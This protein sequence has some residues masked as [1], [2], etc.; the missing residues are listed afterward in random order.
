MAVI[1]DPT[2][3]VISL[4][5]AGAHFGA[6]ICNEPNSFSWNEL[7]TRDIDTAQAFYTQVFEW[8]IAGQDMGEAGVY[9]LVQGGENGGWAGMMSMPAEMPD[10]VPNHWVV[11]FAV[12]DLDD[13]VA[14]VIANGGSIVADPME[15]PG[16]GRM[17][18]AHDPAGGS[19]CV[20]QPAEAA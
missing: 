5:K 16:V 11:H 3:A 6:E 1:A 4:W 7:L 9:Q 20:M 15:I 18:T 19:F 17:A 2:G 10:M 12:A 8:D 13:A 14:K